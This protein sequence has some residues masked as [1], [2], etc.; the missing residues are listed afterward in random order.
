MEHKRSRFKPNI[1]Y[2]KLRIT[3]IISEQYRH[4]FFLL[5]WPVFMAVFYYL[6]HIYP[7]SYYY[8]VQCFLD[9]LIPFCEIFVLPYVIWFALVFLMHAYTLFYDIDG[10]KKMMKFIIVTYSFALAV[11]FVFPNCQQLRPL[12][13]ERV[14]IFTKMAEMFVPLF[15]LW[16]LLP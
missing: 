11:Y 3:N 16:G 13:F 8:P 5:F 14:N 1:D 4:L 9:D 2:R 7:V 6:E 12:E 15:T 10:F